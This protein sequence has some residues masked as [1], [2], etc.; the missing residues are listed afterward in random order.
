MAVWLLVAVEPHTTWRARVRWKYHQVLVDRYSHYNIF[1][2]YTKNLFIP[3]KKVIIAKKVGRK[4]CKEH[5]KKEWVI[6]IW[7]SS[8]MMLF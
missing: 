7:P 1:A 5:S 3:S 4:R 6:L 8:E 2:V